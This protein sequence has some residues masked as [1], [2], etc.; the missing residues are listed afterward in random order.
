MANG[1]VALI[2]VGVFAAMTGAA[3]ASVPLYRA[4]CQATGFSGNVPKASKAA[5]QVLDQKLTVSFDTNVRGLPWN[6][7][8]EQLHQTIKIGETG[9]AFF[10]VTN[11]SEQP[12]TGHAVYNVTPLQAGTY[13]RKLQCFCFTD[14]TIQAHQT[15]RFPVVYFVDPGFARDGDTKAFTDVT[16]SYT[17]YPATPKTAASAPKPQ[18]GLGG[19]AG[20]GL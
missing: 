6:F 8:P 13:F 17:F 1:R 18:Q 10:T 2:C 16:L 4:F 20:A 12:L 3:F 5:G 9:L 7:A 19:P 11:T 14:Q 15:I